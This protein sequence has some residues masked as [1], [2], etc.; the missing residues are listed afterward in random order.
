MRRELMIRFISENHT[1]LRSVVLE[2]CSNEHLR[3]VKDCIKEYLLANGK[4]PC[5][6]CNSSGTVLNIECAFCNGAGVIG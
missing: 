4:T 1:S 5:T 6:T 2:H 3:E